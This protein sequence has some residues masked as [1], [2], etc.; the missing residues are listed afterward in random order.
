MCGDHDEEANVR[1]RIAYLK[2]LTRW[3]NDRARIEYLKSLTTEET[4]Q[5]RLQREE[6]AR[7]VERRTAHRASD[8][9]CKAQQRRLLLCY[10]SQGVL[11][12]PLYP[13]RR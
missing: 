7:K 1:A 12:A 8:A 11:H 13:K 6:Q 9:A 4:P 10:E 3:A 5:Q 2:S